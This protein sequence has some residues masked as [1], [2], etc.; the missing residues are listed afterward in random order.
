MSGTRRFKRAD[1]VDWRG[2]ERSPEF[3]QLVR[4]R[5]RFLI[6]LAV[7]FAAIVLAYLLLASFAHGFMGR[8]VGGLP[9][10]YVAALTQVVL[11]WIVT[12]IYLRKADSTF[13]PL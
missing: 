9:V 2:V 10:A 12:F 11:A 4:A 8:Q 7:V 1:A 13:T 6:P 3:Q 5:R